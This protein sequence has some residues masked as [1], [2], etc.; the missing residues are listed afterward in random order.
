MG[1]TTTMVLYSV[2][3]ILLAGGGV[4]AMLKG[5]SLFRSS[6]ERDVVL[7]S[8][9]LPARSAGLLLLCTSF[10]WAL[11]AA[12]VMPDYLDAE[13]EFKRLEA[14][15]EERGQANATLERELNLRQALLNGAQR[16]EEQADARTEALRQTVDDR[17]QEQMARISELRMALRNDNTAAALRA[18]SQL[19]QLSLAIR[20]AMRER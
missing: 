18:A 4:L 13:V 5:Y 1:V 20:E 11:A 9:T 8:L 7:R 15:L 16:D 10:L 17:L 3:A 14:A 2:V 6:S 12:L 19:E